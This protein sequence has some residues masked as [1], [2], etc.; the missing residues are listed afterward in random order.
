M[1]SSEGVR[2]LLTEETTDAVELPNDTDE[3][4]AVP[5]VLYTEGPAAL[6]L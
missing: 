5:N 6:E 4:V 1:V 2:E 3:N